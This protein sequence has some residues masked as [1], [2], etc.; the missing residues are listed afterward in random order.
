MPLW[1]I[2]EHQPTKASQTEFLLTIPGGGSDFPSSGMRPISI[3]FQILNSDFKQI[4]VCLLSRSLLVGSQGHAEQPC[5][6]PGKTI[7][8]N[9][10]SELYFA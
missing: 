10:R 7:N 9:F 1:N 3:N 5:T 6:H 4:S 2:A 8:G